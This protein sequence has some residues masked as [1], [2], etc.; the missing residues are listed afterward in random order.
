MAVLLWKGLGIVDLESCKTGKPIILITRFFCILTTKIHC[1]MSSFFA[2]YARH[3]GHTLGQLMVT[4][5]IFELDV[6]ILDIRE[7][8]TNKNWIMRNRITLNDLLRPLVHK[9][10][11]VWGWISWRYLEAS[12]M[13]GCCLLKVLKVIFESSGGSNISGCFFKP[14]CPSVISRFSGS[15]ENDP[16]GFVME[17]S[18]TFKEIIFM[19]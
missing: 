16:S 12:K 6:F 7:A 15:S 3:E 17:T 1:L 11:S 9:E 5:L 14:F 10:Q 2:S 13:S 18:R 4:Q 19:I 8:D